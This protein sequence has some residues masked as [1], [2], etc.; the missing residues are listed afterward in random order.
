[1]FAGHE[2]P[3]FP[4]NGFSSAGRRSDQYGVPSGQRLDRLQLEIVELI[5]QSR[6]ELLDDPFGWHWFTSVLM[7]HSGLP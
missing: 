2:N 6:D 1:V 5:R 4:Y 7:Q 3:K